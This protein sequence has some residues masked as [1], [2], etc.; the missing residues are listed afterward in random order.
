MKQRLSIAIALLG[1]PEFLVLD[2]PMN[3]LDP[4]G[5]REIRELLLGLHAKR[6]LT[7]LMSSHILGELGKIAT[8]YGIINSG[9]MVEEFSAEDLENR[10]KHY[11]HIT[12]NDCEKAQRVLA[13]KCNIR[14]C[15]ILE[16]QSLGVYE[17]IENAAL[18]NQALVQNDVLVSRLVSEGQDMEMYFVKRMGGY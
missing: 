3:G 2:E 6:Q 12:V 7:I 16:D 8:K 18:I 17:Q 14:E 1:D 5:I 4:A 11:L 15:R 10:V 9:V 13:D